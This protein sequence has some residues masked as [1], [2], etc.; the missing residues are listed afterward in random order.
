MDDCELRSRTRSCLS[1][2][3]QRIARPVWRRP[4]RGNGAFFLFRDGAAARDALIASGNAENAAAKIER[5]LQSATE[6]DWQEQVGRAKIASAS[7]TAPG[8]LLVHL[9]DHLSAARR[10]LE[11][12][13]FRQ[14]RVFLEL[15]RPLSAELPTAP[16]GAGLRIVGYSPTLSEQVRAAHNEAFA[17]HWGSEPR[18]REDWDR[19]LGNRHFR[20]DWSFVVLD[21]EDG[22]GGEPLL[23]KDLPDLIALAHQAFDGA[24]RASGITRAVT[25]CSLADLT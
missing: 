23:R 18:S 12:A 17:D 8:R 13:G 2:D 24:A 20:A 25:T 14:L 1:A 11:R 22:P 16:L 15:S 9:D 4:Q 6:L 5:S 19:T 3:G 21:G 10:L 7:T